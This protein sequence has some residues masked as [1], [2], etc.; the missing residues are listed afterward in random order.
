MS[1]T[2]IA[3]PHFVIL[4]LNAINLDTSDASTERVRV[5]NSNPV[6]CRAP[7][8]RNFK[9]TPEPGNA[10]I[11]VQTIAAQPE[12]EDVL[13]RGAI[14]PARRT[15]VPGPAAASGVRWHGIDVAHR[16]VRFDFVL[17]HARARRSVIDRIQQAKQLPGPI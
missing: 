5:L 1:L 4:L 8:K 9:L 14:H 7:P 10:R 2:V 13:E 17:V 15:R 3:E 12:A 6:S 11:K 16:N